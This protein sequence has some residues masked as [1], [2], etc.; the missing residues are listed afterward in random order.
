[1]W[2]RR[3]APEIH[4]PR[5]FAE[6]LALPAAARVLFAEDGSGSSLAS[7]AIEAPQSLLAI[8]GA[9]GGFSADE[10]DAPRRAGCHLVGL[11]PRILRAET[12]AVTAVV[13]CQSRWGDLGGAAGAGAVPR[14]ALCVPR[15]N[16]NAERTTR[17]A[18]PVTR[19]PCLRPLST[20]PISRPCASPSSWIRSSASCP[21][22]TR[23]S[24]SCSRPARAATRSITWAST[25]CGCR[26]RCRMSARAAGGGGAAYGAE[27]GADKVGASPAVRRAQDTPGLVR[28]GVHAQGPAVRH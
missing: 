3:G 27:A 2:G 12:A 5:A 11:G 15:F 9:D 28:R 10:L 26:G 16:P 19:P 24:C 25:I 18:E 8:L 4:S 13:L 23:P 22:R 17:N 20:P 6:V 7:I 1:Q 14:G 21:T